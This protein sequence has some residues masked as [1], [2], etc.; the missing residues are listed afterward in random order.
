M[1]FDP[2]AFTFK[3]DF[4]RK[5]VE[6]EA[7]ADFDVQIGGKLPSSPSSIDPVKLE[8]QLRRVRLISI[9]F[10]ELK[11]LLS[12]ADLGAGSE[13]AICEGQ[14]RIWERIHHLTPEQQQY[15]DGLVDEHD[16]QAE[17][18]TYRIQLR[19]MFCTLLTSEDWQ[20]IADAAT[21]TMRDRL[22]QQVTEGSNVA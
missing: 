13:A 7:S 17:E 20:A 4:Y 8:F 12:A 22:L 15:F 14:R 11:A 19:S 3:N 6:F 1:N 18:K 21:E 5:G 16:N 10:G 9:L 2:Q